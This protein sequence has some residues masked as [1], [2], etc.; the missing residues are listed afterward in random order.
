MTTNLV[1]WK[2]WKGETS[3]LSGILLTH[4]MLHVRVCKGSQETEYPVAVKHIFLFSLKRGVTT[5]HTN[6]ENIL[7]IKLGGVALW[8]QACNHVSKMYPSEI[9]FLFPFFHISNS[10]RS[11]VSRLITFLVTGF[12]AGQEKISLCHSANWG[13]D[14]AP[15]H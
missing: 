5:T 15:V 14:A 9:L 13:H 2:G 4:I 1:C 8:L 12:A 6:H 3:M 10:S 7:E 11:L